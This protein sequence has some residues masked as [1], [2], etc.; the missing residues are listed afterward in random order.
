V[1]K[2]NDDKFVT[3]YVLRSLLQMAPYAMIHLKAGQGTFWLV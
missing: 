2:E 3:K 1:S